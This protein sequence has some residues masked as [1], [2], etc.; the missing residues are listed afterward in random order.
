MTDFLRIPPPDE[1]SYEAAE[2]NLLRRGMSMSFDQ[3]LEWLEK[4]KDLVTAFQT[5][6]EM[7]QPTNS[8]TTKPTE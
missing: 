2:W 1:M 4:A 5:P 8:P 3:Q 6:R 7:L